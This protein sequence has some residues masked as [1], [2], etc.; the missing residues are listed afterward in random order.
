MTGQRRRRNIVIE[1][2]KMELNSGDVEVCKLP[3]PWVVVLPAWD[4]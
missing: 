4:H 2:I 1:V 3:T